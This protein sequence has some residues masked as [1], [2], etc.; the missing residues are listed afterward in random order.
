MD[1]Q[2]SLKSAMEFLNEILKM[3]KKKGVVKDRKYLL[4][5]ECL[6]EMSKCDGQ[7]VIK[8]IPYPLCDEIARTLEEKG[9]PHAACPTPG[10]LAFCVPLNHSQ[11]FEDV[12]VNACKKS[13]Q[14][15]KQFS[16]TDMM[17]QG[18]DAGFNEMNV[19]EFNS[20]QNFRD[21]AAQKMY[22]A[23][24]T[25]ATKDEKD[26][27]V[28][29]SS[30]LIPNARGTYSRD[31]K[32]LALAQLMIASEIAKNSEAFGKDALGCLDKRLEQAGYD[33]LVVENFA[34]K[35]Q[36]KTDFV[37]CSYE[38]RSGN[39]ESAG[40]FSDVYIECKDG[41]VNVC[42]RQSD[43]NIQKTSLA[44]DEHATT[45]EITAMISSYT[46]NIDNM[47]VVRHD[48]FVHNDMSHRYPQGD[49]P[50]QFNN[51]NISPEE[52]RARTQLSKDVDVY[53]KM[54]NEEATRKTNEVYGKDGV[55][56]KNSDR[57]NAYQ[58][59]LREMNRIMNDPNSEP[60]L[61]FKASRSGE[62]YGSKAIDA[63]VKDLSD[64]LDGSFD[65]TKVKDIPT[66]K[67][68]TIKLSKKNIKAE[69]E[70][71]YEKS[72]KRQQDMNLDR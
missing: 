6:K 44:I 45:E 59:K 23:G 40:L 8:D 24:L 69:A 56:V 70:K 27:G 15:Y 34:E 48:D 39:E 41:V 30:K 25:C 37:L 5:E 62:H 28:V 65:N 42:S 10:G 68:D 49:R 64:C 35:I 61:A 4:A 58:M 11:E 1:A 19:L 18:Y 3:L 47:C 46:E 60:N 66:V 52:K 67:F 50:S 9:I 22:Q 55:S 7:G 2:T 36:N 14:A 53:M 63:Y 33:R 57:M 54:V 72:Q 26:G 38:G 51:Q 12:L 43:G 20:N 13:S 16:Y 29:T 21:L 31:G 17:Q 32:D 71:A